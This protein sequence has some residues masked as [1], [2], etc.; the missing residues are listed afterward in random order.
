[1]TLNLDDRC[2]NCDHRLGDHDP[3]DPENGCT[4]NILDRNGLSKYCWCILDRRRAAGEGPVLPEK[5]G[6]LAAKL[7]D[8]G[9]STR[10]A[11]VWVE[12]VLRDAW[13]AGARSLRNGIIYGDGDAPVDVLDLPTEEE[14]AASC[15]FLPDDD[16]DE[17]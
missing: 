17:R 8:A 1:M 14:I 2:T 13:I 9:L 3:R 7:E 15:P 10:Q 4:F 6:Q 11:Q 12:D 5:A 16:E